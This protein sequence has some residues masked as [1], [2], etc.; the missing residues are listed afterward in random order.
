[1]DQRDATS[2]NGL[3]NDTM[4]EFR[5]LKAECVV[6]RNQNQQLSERVD[7]L[8]ALVHQFMVSSFHGGGTK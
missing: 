3:I 7:Q 1:M 6:L 8:Q 4:A 5:Q 2:I